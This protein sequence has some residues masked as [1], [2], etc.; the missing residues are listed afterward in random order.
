MNTDFCNGKA[1]KVDSEKLKEKI[2]KECELLLET[3][4][5]KDYFPGPQ[6]VAVEKKDFEVLKKKKYVVC[7]KTDGE[8]G[9]LILINIDNK[10]MCFIIKRNNDILFLQLSFKKEVFEGSIFDGEIIKTNKGDWNYLIHDCMVYNSSNFKELSHP[11]R[12]AAILDLIT[13]RYVNKETDVFNIKTKIFYNYFPN[14]SNN[15]GVSKTWKHISKTTEN[16]IDGLIFT[17]VDEPITFGRQYSLLKWKEKN[18]NTIDLL[19]K[20][21]QKK[22]VLYYYKNGNNIVFKNIPLEN[23]NHE[24]IMDF[25]ILNNVSESLKNG[26]IIEFKYSSIPEELFTPYRI[27]D[28]KSKPN[29]EITVKNTLKNIEEA[30]SIEDFV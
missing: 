21:I 28:D 18:D 22:L 4:L 27:R 12:Y 3:S 1:C 7:E 23:I 8:R 6:P 24:L 20:K 25:L 17:P 19:V 26:I 11:L 30:I 15:P 9:I 10:P 14:E 2:L 16:K 13:K 29:G 5:Q